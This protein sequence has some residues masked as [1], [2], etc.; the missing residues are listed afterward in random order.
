ASGLGTGALFT[1]DVVKSKIEDGR[2]RVSGIATLDRLTLD[3]LAVESDRFK[4]WQN[5]VRASYEVLEG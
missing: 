5:R 3:R 2:M 1:D 4:W